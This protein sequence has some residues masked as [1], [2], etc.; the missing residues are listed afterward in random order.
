M[1]CKRTVILKGRAPVDPDC[2]QKVYTAHVL[3]EGDL[4]WDAMLNQV[5]FKIIIIEEKT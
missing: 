5:I 2:I 4:I 3:E 1:E